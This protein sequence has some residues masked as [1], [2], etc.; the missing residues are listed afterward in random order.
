ME[1]STASR[2]PSAL[3]NT[4]PARAR[5][6]AFGQAWLDGMW[7]GDPLA[8]V[9]VDGGALV[10]RAIAD[11]IETLD[12]PPAALVALFASLDS[13][14]AWLEIDRCD[15]GAEHLARQSREYS[16]VLG[17]A[18]L[19]A[20]AQNHIASKPLSFTG[21]YASDA[22]TRS[23]EVGSWLSAVTTP[24][25]L[26]RDRAGFA[27]TVRVRM[28]HAHIRAHLARRP[29][30]DE[31]AWGVP[32][33]QS[34][35]AFTLAEF[36]SIALRAMARLGVRYT[37]S[38]REDVMHLWR[39][40]GHLVG[41]DD[42]LLPRTSG[43]YRRIEALY[44]LTSP[45]AADDEREFV[46]ALTD[47]QSVELARWLPSRYTSPIVNGLQRAF[48]GDPIADDLAI[49][50]TWCKHLPRVIAPFTV[51]AY[52]AH[53]RLVPGG[54]ARRAARA[55]RNRTAM[56]DEIRTRYGVSHDLVDEVA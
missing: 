2:A 29:E 3:R 48:V 42:E 34:Y 10:R 46:R 52:G 5:F 22:A 8:D 43:D 37:A 38:E 36:C 25:G 40:V 32:I 28:I 39:Y 20:G 31:R 50:D 1:L 30:W 16:L 33:P 17:A 18:S 4:D 49:P 47:F 26:R 27:R 15:R 21:R 24:G 6:A 54:K 13:P 44:A 19:L 56:L 11:G 41:I 12:D 9:V 45:G 51:C 7:R 53:D 14:P 23:I 35:L 55:M